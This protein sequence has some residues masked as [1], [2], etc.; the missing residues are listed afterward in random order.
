MCNCERDFWI[1]TLDMYISDTLVCRSY[2]ID[3]DGD[4]QGEGHV[5]L[6]IWERSVKDKCGVRQV[7]YP[8][9][10]RLVVFPPI[11]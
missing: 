2:R 11:R 5:H 1:I 3:W 10:P 6:L 9:S 8:Q 7:Y 4:W